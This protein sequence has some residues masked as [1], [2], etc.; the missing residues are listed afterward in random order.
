MG[1][2]LNS[3]SMMDSRLWANTAV[4]SATTTPVSSGPRWCWLSSAAAMAS[5]WA[6]AAPASLMKTSTPH[7]VDILPRG[8]LGRGWRD[9]SPHRRGRAGNMTDTPKPEGEVP[10][11]AGVRPYDVL[12]PE[13][14]L[15]FMRTG[16]GD[17]VLPVSTRP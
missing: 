11:D 6:A 9:G 3:T 7:M 13:A 12:Y 15:N 17:S 5:L 10:A 4:W 1:S 2:W 16:W 8:S 14:F